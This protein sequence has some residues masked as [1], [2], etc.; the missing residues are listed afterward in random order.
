M[1]GGTPRAC[2]A[3]QG[4]KRDGRDSGVKKA[5]KLAAAG[6]HPRRHCDFGDA[7]LFHRGGK[8]LGDDFLDGVI[9]ARS[10]HALIG[11]EVVKGLLAYAAFPF[12]GH[13]VTSRLR[14]R[15]KSMSA[16]GVFC[17]FL[18]KPCSKIM[19][20]SPMQKIT[21]AIRWLSS[22]ERTSH[23]PLPSGA[24]CGRPIGQVAILQANPRTDSQRP[25]CTKALHAYVDLEQAQPGL[26][27]RQDSQKVAQESQDGHSRAPN[28]K[29]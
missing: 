5:I 28:E 23:K 9:L 16:C 3:A 10:Q 4:V 8:L 14:F 11:K 7:L 25:E 1:L 13:H 17:V 27:L 12:L 21:R 18:M 22:A 2:G 15:A 29:N 24:Q 26:L 6:S 20:P 19:V